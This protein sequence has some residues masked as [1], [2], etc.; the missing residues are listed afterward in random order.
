MISLYPELLSTAIMGSHQLQNERLD[1][2]V[3][4]ILCSY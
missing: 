3:W 4:E 1:Y 2:F